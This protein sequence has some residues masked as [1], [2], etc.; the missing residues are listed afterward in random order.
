MLWFEPRH[1]RISPPSEKQIINSAL[2]HCAV[3]S[4]NSIKSASL[5][6]TFL[7]FFVIF[8]LN[9]FGDKILLFE[10]YTW[11]FIE[12]IKARFVS[13]SSHH[14]LSPVSDMWEGGISCAT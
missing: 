10:K 2:C 13:R 1:A 9:F 5:I 12:L 4:Q 6:C 3:S 11:P 8:F 14:P 7:F